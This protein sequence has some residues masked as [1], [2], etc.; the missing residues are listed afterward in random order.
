LKGIDHLVLCG[1]DLESMR[2][3]YAALGFTLTPP[4]QH[5]FGTHNSL[6]QLDQVFLELLSIANPAAIPEHQAHRFSF[7]AFNR[8]FLKRGAGFSMLVLD[9]D[10][11]RRDAAAFRE[12]GL[13]TYEPF[14]FRRQARLPNGEVVTVGFSLTF[15]S[16]P[17]MP[18]CG[19]FCCQ[20]HAPQYFWQRHYQTH[21]NGAKLVLEVALVAPRPRDLVSFLENFSGVS[22]SAIEGGFKIATARGDIAV[23]TSETFVKAYASPPPDSVPEPRFAGYTVGLDAADFRSEIAKPVHLFGCTIRLRPVPVAERIKRQ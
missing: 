12:R 22:S 10:D 5:P 8:D 15:V 16:S 1:N 3:A 7:A 19:F 21:P 18:N 13:T 6:I 23:I 2:S 14:D 11:V 9:S 17:L 20:Q 4:A